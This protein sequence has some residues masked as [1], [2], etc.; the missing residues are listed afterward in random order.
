MHSESFKK[1]LA[2]VGRLLVAIPFIGFGANHFFKPGKYLEY[3]PSYIPF[4]E[5]WVYF[6]A[7][8]MIL[9]AISMILNY[10]ARLASLLLALMISLFIILIYLPEFSHNKSYIASYVIFIGSSLL[11]A[12]MAKN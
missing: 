9:A 4:P 10:R 7:V 2:I 8:C 1:F 6:V 5:F 11:V 12:S 3:V